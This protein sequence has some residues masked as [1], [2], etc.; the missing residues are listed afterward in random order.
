MSHVSL[1]HY[2]LVGIVTSIIGFALVLGLTVISRR[3]PSLWLKRVGLAI[4]CGVVMGIGAPWLL[5][6]GISSVLPYFFLWSGVAFALAIFR[7]KS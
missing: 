3:Y 6:L 5:G 4:I 2:M 1:A 7:V